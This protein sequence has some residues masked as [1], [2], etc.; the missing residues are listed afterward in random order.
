MT[1]TEGRS[2]KPEDSPFPRMVDMWFLAMCMAVKEG[3]QPVEE[4]EG[5]TY[6]AIEGVVLGSDVWRS[7]AI[8]LVAIAYT[9]GIEITSSA[10]EMMKIANGFAVAGLPILVARLE[11][12]GGDTALDY[13]SDEVV[14]MLDEGANGGNAM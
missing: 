2:N 14:R 5:P 12:R 13:L 11:E 8:M 9:G 4:L 7:D 6:K 10:S 3:L 1:R